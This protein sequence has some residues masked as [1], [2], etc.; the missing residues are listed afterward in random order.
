[1]SKIRANIHNPKLKTSLLKRISLSVSL[2]LATLL[3]YNLNVLA[4]NPKVRDA[5]SSAPIAKVSIFDRNGKMIATGDNNGLLPYIHPSSYPITLR[6]LGYSDKIVSS[7]KE[8]LIEMS[9]IA[10]DL[11]EVNVNTKRRPILHL[12]GYLREIS[13]MASSFDNVM[14]YREK[15]VDFMIPAPNEKHFKGWTD[16]RILK[17]KSYY[18]FTDSAGLDSVSD[19]INHHFSW[20]DWLSL[21]PRVNQ[22]MKIIRNRNI[23][24]TVMGKYSAAETWKRDGEKIRVDVDVLADTLRG[25]WAPRLN[26]RLWNDLDFERLNL[27]FEYSYCD[28]FAVKPQNIDRMSCYIESMGRGHDMFQFQTRYDNILYVTTYVDLVIADREYIT[29]KEARKKEKDQLYA[30]QEATLVLEA[31]KMPRDSVISDLIAR[32]NEIDHDSR[33][34]AM[35]LDTRVG[36]GHMPDAPVYR[37]KDK[38]K[39]ALK[40][41]FSGF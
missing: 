2:I 27:T 4:A 19:R 32:V 35:E 5:E 16:P 11:P 39:R 22:P 24:D 17:T 9:A 20:S 37:N 25:K 26:H 29:V 1:M 14:L 30:L 31:E 28:T 15:W 7:P 10:F 36:N 8:A 18:K 23:S 33:R 38:V 34:L 21:P 40:S 13:S 12:T 41:I 6:C 3:I